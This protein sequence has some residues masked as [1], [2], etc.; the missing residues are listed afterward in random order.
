MF[1]IEAKKF[2]VESNPEITRFM[3]ID[4][5]YELLASSPVHVSQP[6]LKRLKKA[7]VRVPE[8]SPPPKSPDLVL[9]SNSEEFG[10]FHSDT[11]LEESNAELESLNVAAKEDDLGAARVLDFDSVDVELD[12]NVEASTMEMDK[13]EEVEDLK[14]QELETKRPSLDSSTDNKENKKKKKKKR[15]D[16]DG[17]AEKNA[18][19]SKSNKRKAEK[20][21]M[22][23]PIR[24][25]I[26]F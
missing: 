10:T 8:F 24:P 17:R 22:C 3:E 7:A 26:L 5:D 18:K 21:H 11:P 23:F 19:E 4:D 16:D 12:E 15:I 9:P 20:V 1:R 25:V 13:G 6:K 14:T 2:V